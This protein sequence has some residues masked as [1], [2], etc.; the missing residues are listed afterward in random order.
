MSET[1]PVYH[2][3]ISA[4]QPER[5]RIKVERGQRGTYAW[6]VSYAGEDLDEVLARVREADRRLREEYGGG[7]S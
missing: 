6:E 7:E 3:H 4:Q 5:L 2:V 1:P